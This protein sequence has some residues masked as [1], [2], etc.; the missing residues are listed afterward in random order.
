MPVSFIDTV[1]M[2]LK[3]RLSNG[4]FVCERRNGDESIRNK[5]K[6]LRRMKYIVRYVRVWHGTSTASW[7]FSSNN[8]FK[9]CTVHFVSSLFRF[10]SI[11]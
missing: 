5:L 6:F 10:D 7:L 11:L 9:P 3:H 8:N 4:G 2:D 1:A